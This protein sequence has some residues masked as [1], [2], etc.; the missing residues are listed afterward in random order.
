MLHALGFLFGCI[1]EQK[2]WTDLFVLLAYAREASSTIIQNKGPV[3]HVL[4]FLFGRTIE[5]KGWTDLFVLLAYA[6]KANSTIIQNK[7]P[8]RN[9]GCFV[10]VIYCD[11]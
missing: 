1:I 5:Q 11:A 7:G 9:G 6:R 10:R 4:G 2:G 3:L 8:A